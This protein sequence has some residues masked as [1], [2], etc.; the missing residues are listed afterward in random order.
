LEFLAALLPEPEEFTE[1][2]AELVL[3]FVTIGVAALVTDG[4]V[5]LAM[6]GVVE[7]VTVG[8]AALVTGEVV[9]FVTVEVTPLLTVGVVAFVTVGVVVRSSL[10]FGCVTCARATRPNNKV[11]HSSAATI[12]A[13]RRM[14]SGPATVRTPPSLA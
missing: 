14:P 13:P 11:K 9:A 2:L 7:F 10:E 3:P 4:V 5:A 6:D 12:A 8:V 1:P